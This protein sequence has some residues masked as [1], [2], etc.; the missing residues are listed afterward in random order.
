MDESNRGVLIGLSSIIAVSGAVLLWAH[1]NS[2]A[3]MDFIER[4][5]GFS[6]TMATVHWKLCSLVLVMIVTLAAFRWASK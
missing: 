6:P 4:H 3:P 1:R 2:A 5:L